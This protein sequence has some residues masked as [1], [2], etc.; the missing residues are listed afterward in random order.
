MISKKILLTVA[1]LLAVCARIT[2]LAAGEEEQSKSSNKSPNIIFILTDDQGYGDLQRHGHPYLQT[3]N[4]N[5]LHDES[6]RFDS[7][8]VSPSCSPTRAALMTGMHEFRN[9]VTHTLIP[10]EHLYIDATTL[11]QLLKTAGYKTGF[12]GKWHL[13]G[14]H[15]YAPDARGFDWTATN[16]MG[17]RKHFDPEIIRNGKRTQREGF[18]ED[19]FFDE[20]MTF[21]EESGDQP[22]FCYLATYS[23]HTP[24]GAPE[25]FIAP[26]R[27]QGLSEKHATYLAMIENVDYNVGRLLAFMEERGLDE[28]TIVIFMNDNGVTEG[29][30]VYNAGMRGC[31]ATAWEGGTRAMSFWRWPNHWQPHTVDN[32]TAHVDVLP[33]L[34]EIAGVE[35][36]PELQ[37][38]LEGF[39]LMPLIESE[40]PISWHDD[41]T[42]FHHVG[43]WP[44]GLA[45]SHKYAMVSAHRGDYLLIRSAPCGDPACEQF[46]SQCT[47]MRAV[48]NGLT[49]TTYSDG[50]AQMHWGTTPMGHWALYNV[51]EDP[52]CQ[53]DISSTH[54]EVVASMAAS[55]DAWWDELYPTM[56]ERGGDLGDP[57]ASAHASARAK[58]WKGPNSDA[59]LKGEAAAGAAAD[60][61]SRFDRIDANGDSKITEEEYVGPF[62]KQI[63]AKDSNRDG[64][65]SVEEFNVP[66]FKAVDADG[67]G[68]L[69]AAEIRKFYSQ[70]FQQ[71]DRDQSGSIAADEM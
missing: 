29:L 23:P 38:E 40:Q 63:S 44:S 48:N 20:A 16:P 7:F 66:H 4:T 35:V 2:T 41:R 50:T 65:L 11:P 70:Q 47:T 10:R 58:Q 30:D 54:P 13:G 67:D 15:G 31:K 19:I 52:A 27:E 61:M 24:L 64:M 17:P 55:Y 42:L 22:F 49:T 12:I 45:E 62:L 57:L 33:T 26:F 9:G 32:L 3:P 28:N 51:K 5:R 25:K 6:V 1:V 68:Q 37:S 36:P 69:T 34:C 46:Q 71:I 39:S 8:Y 53:N 18:R 21:I 43:R 56:I 60:T 59:D 14:S